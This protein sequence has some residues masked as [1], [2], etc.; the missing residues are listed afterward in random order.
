MIQG[1]FT[2][3][4]GQNSSATSA[5][6]LQPGQSVVLNGSS[7]LAG[8]VVANDNAAVFSI[9]LNQ[10]SGVYS[11]QVTVDAQGPEGPFSGSMYLYF[12]DQTGDRYPLT[13]LR[14]ARDT[15]TVSYNSAAPAIVKIDW[16]NTAL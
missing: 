6:G 3:Q 1:H 11:Y 14:H 7:D 13:V 15:H 4:C 12:T 16:S 2:G 9:S 8:C 10:I 5:A